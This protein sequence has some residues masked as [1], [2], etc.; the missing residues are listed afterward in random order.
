MEIKEDKNNSV[1][2]IQV[3]GRIDASTAPELE[4]KFHDLLESGEQNFL[5][6]LSNMD[7]ISSVGLRV[8][9][10][11]AKRTKTSSGKVVLCNLQ[12]QVYEVFEISGFT[13]IFQICPDQDEAI[14][15]F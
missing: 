2:I 7:Y 13:S 10:V 9:L 3:L 15:L 4:K 6:D 5:I 14:R 8:L 12:E 1:Y 11:L